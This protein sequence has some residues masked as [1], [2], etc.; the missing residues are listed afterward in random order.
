MDSS[1]FSVKLHRGMLR[2]LASTLRSYRRLPGEDDLMISELDFGTRAELEDALPR[3]EAQSESLPGRLRDTMFF[4]VVH[5]APGAIHVKAIQGGGRPGAD[6]CALA[7]HTV[8]QVSREEK[9]VLVDVSAIQPGGAFEGQTFLLS[10]DAIPW[11][12][13]LHLLRWE[14][15]GE[16]AWALPDSFLDS[17][18]IAHGQR[19]HINAIFQEL[20]LQ[21]PVDAQPHVAEESA[22]ADRQALLRNLIE[23]DVLKVASMNKPQP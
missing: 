15:S 3:L 7:P 18:N 10:F 17:E 4:H 12:D 2:D 22:A 14:V 8:R 19:P 11:R 20:L 1:Y 23:A 9:Y 21:V 5:R 13:M 6:E 16:A